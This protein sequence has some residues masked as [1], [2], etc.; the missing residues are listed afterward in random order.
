MEMV[1]LLVGA[2]CFFCGGGLSW[3]LWKKKTRKESDFQRMLWETKKAGLEEKVSEKQETVTVL[4]GQVSQLQEEKN[5]LCSNFAEV[6]AHLEQE[7]KVAK[8]KEELLSKA[9]NQFSDAFKAL[10]SDALKSNNE[11]F[12]KLA[13][14]SLEKFQEGAKHDL[15]SRH[16]VIDGLVKPIKESLDKV[17]TKI[18][19]M[20]KSRSQVDGVLKEQIGSLAQA[21]LKLQSETANLVKALRMPTVRGR[22]GEIQLK[23][24]VE[25]AGMLPRPGKCFYRRGAFKA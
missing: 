10:S 5:H 6:K 4:Q 7:R 20:E 18:H 2:L 16:K 22:W 14:A 23:R 3:F 24:V 25:M 1:H 8:E 11:S 9:Q 17:G 15:E 19:E 13:N 21:E 12:L